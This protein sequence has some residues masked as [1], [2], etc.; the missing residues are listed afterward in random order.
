MRREPRLACRGSRSMTARYQG[1]ARLP[2]V[3]TEALLARIG[4]VETRLPLEGAEIL[5]ANCTWI[6]G[7]AG[8]VV[9]RAIVRVVVVVVATPRTIGLVGDDATDHDTGAEPEPGA[10]SPAA[11]VATISPLY[12]SN[13]AY[14]GLAKGRGC[15]C[16]R[17]GFRPADGARQCH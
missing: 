2:Q 8:G 10:R 6:A 11:P 4:R 9:V 15:G 17:S 12:L 16:S 1:F 7:I 13:R 14:F 3:R 5:G